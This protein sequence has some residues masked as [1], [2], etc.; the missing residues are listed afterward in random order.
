[1]KIDK[2]DTGASV[3][4]SK[5]YSSSVSSS[6]TNSHASTAGQ[7]YSVTEGLSF[8]GKIPLLN[9]NSTVNLSSSQAFNF[10]ETNTVSE[11]VTQTETN[12]DGL[13][14]TIPP[15]SIA[16]VNCTSADETRNQSYDCP[17]ALTYD[18]A[19]LG[20]G[21]ELAASNLFRTSFA[22]ISDYYAT[23]GAGE[24][25]AVDVLHNIYK[26][27]GSKTDGFTVKCIDSNNFNSYSSDE[28]NKILNKIS[29]VTNIRQ[30]LNRQ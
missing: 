26:S 11:A 5:S 23:F 25:S 17:I 29:Q 16:A 12:T 20:S 24:N 9:V 15:Y 30:R 8:G 21:C 7:T 6:T 10:S 22:Y 14:Y 2:N 13:S 3:N 19:F 28:W 4:S 27:N 1:M 18:V